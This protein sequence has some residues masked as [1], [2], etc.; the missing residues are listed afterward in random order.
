VGERDKSKWDIDL[1]AKQLG[2]L[3]VCF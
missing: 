3:C 2:R 1:A